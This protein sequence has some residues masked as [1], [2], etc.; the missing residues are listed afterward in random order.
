MMNF[1]QLPA[2]MM[3]FGG[4]EIGATPNAI[5]QSGSGFDFVDLREVLSLSSGIPSQ[6]LS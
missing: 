1:S 4:V 3:Y 6:R 5:R 2:K